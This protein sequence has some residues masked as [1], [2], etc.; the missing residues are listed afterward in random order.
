MLSTRLL[1]SFL[2]TSGVSGWPDQKQEA[3]SAVNQLTDG[4]ADVRD[5]L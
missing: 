5:T 2:S 1:G 4:Y 3:P